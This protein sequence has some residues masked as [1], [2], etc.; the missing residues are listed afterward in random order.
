M[1]KH[2]RPLP[3]VIDE[4]DEGLRLRP[5]RWNPNRI[6]ALCIFA[7]S[8]GVFGF[9]GFRFGSLQDSLPILAPAALFILFCICMTAFQVPRIRC[10][11]QRVNIRYRLLACTF[12]RGF[13]VED[14][15]H[16]AVGFQSQRQG[17]AFEVACVMRNGEYWPLG[18]S[19]KGPAVEVADAVAAYYG[20]PVFS[21][22][23]TT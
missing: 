7:V 2:L 20:V 4:I 22:A 8:M 17:R 16:V 10:D 19:K 13:D 11:R 9:M 5:A 3:T 21:T 15:K 23:E 14:L 6:F 1:Y 12:Y 18:I